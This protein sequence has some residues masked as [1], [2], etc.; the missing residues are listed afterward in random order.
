MRTLPLPLLFLFAA[1]TAL[2]PLAM[3]LYL[4]A[5]GAAASSLHASSGR[6]AY[7]LSICI[8]GVGVGQLFYGPLSDRLGR[9]LPLLFGIGVFVL[10]SIG[11]SQ[12]SRFEVFLGFRLL[13]GLGASATM[14][15][16]RAIVVDTFDEQASAA[17]LSNIML[18]FALA[19]MIAPVIGGQLLGLFGWTAIF[20]ALAVI[21]GV[22]GLLTWFFVPE[23]LG[24]AARRSESLG[25]TMRAYGHLLV[26]P[27]LMLVGA[28]GAL[29]LAA[30]VAFISG[31]PHVYMALHGVTPGRYG[32]CIGFNA[33][34]IMAAGH[35]NVV[36]LR[37]FRVESLL[38]VSL[39]GGAVLGSA[40]AIAGATGAGGLPALV[41]LMLLYTG[42]FA[43]TISN[44]SVIAM[45]QRTQQVGQ[46]SALL[47]MLQNGIGMLGG[48]AVGAFHDGT[49]R[50]MTATIAVAAIGGLVSYGLARRITGQ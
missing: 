21:G 14:P 20:H 15:L 18:A 5:F 3:D 47:G 37:Q 39:A 33:L 4:P 29:G 11:C 17:I 45:G 31:S 34:G 44:S 22:C 1:L 42:T 16:V 35:L 50:P 7:T 46:A 40:L 24:P 32:L 49:A 25:V 36:L 27:R 13:Q 43:I 48:V 41:L 8:V 19:P 23:S 28:T 10:A 26:E 30:L 12:A 9:R 38:G 2:G 6:M